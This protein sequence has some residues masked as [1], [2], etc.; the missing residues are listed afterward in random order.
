MKEVIQEG[1]TREEALKVALEKLGADEND[2][3]IE[4]LETPREGLFG[5][6]GSRNIKLRVA[7]VNSAPEPEPE[8]DPNLIAST[9]HG[10]PQSF[11]DETPEDQVRDFLEQVFKCLEVEC[12][13]DVCEGQNDISVDITGK[14][15]GVV[16]GKFGQTLD[17][18]QFIT[19]V[20][21]TKKFG[22]RKKVVINVG[23][24]RKR[25]EESVH[26]MARS[27]ARKVMKT[28]KPEALAPMPPQ[29]RRI[30]HLAL[31]DYK[32]IVT[33]SEGTGKNRKV[34]ISYK[35]GNPPR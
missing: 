13:I 34:V 16:I 20:V 18:L 26:K 12:D 9:L 8:P 4:V 3:F 15:S 30:I 27:V 6:I 33:T 1:R 11:S 23:D 31:A 14:D 5:L 29:D 10:H 7:L 28:H 2:V 17:S 24:Y 25:R 19:N 21:M 32:N 35:S 22:N